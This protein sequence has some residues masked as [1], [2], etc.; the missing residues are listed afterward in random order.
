MVF[1]PLTIF[2]SDA[3]ELLVPIIVPVTAAVDP[4][5]VI[6]NVDGDEGVKLLPGVK[7]AAGILLN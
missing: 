2:A 7:Q 1:P 6:V 3:G 5:G 4:A